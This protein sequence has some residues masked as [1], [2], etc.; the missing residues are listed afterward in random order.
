ME[1]TESTAFAAILSSNLLTVINLQYKSSN[2]KLLK[3]LSKKAF[4]VA[5][6]TGLEPVTL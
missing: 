1:I 2:M 6:Q 5:P 4:T 3:G